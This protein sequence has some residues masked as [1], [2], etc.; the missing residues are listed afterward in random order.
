MKKNFLFSDYT[1][2]AVLTLM[3]GGFFYFQSSFFENMELMFYDLRAQMREQP[4]VAKRGNE[5]VI[6]EID[7]DS[8]IKIGRWPW[9]RWRIVQLIDE[10]AL[11]EPKVVAL[12]LLFSEPESN[13]GLEEIRELTGKYAFM[14]LQKQ[15]RERRGVN[16]LAELSSAEV[17]LDNDTKLMTSIYDAQNVLLAMS[18]ALGGI[19]GALVPDEEDED[20]E[21]PYALEYSFLP[22]PTNP[23]DELIFPPLEAAGADLPLDEF[24]EGSLGAGHVTVVPDEDGVLR[25]ESPFIK[26]YGKYYPSLAMQAVRT[27]LGVKQEDISITLGQSMRM[28]KAVIPLDVDNRM[29][30]SYV[31]KGR[32][33]TYFSYYDV[34][35]QK[36]DGAAFKNKIVLVAFT[37][38]GLGSLY[39]T[40]L[41]SNFPGVEYV[42][43]VIQNVLRQNFITRPPW[44]FWVEVGSLAVIGLFVTLLLPRLHAGTGFLVSLGLAIALIAPTSYMFVKDGYWIKIFYSFFLLAAFGSAQRRSE[45]SAIRSFL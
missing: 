11:F 16:F 18:F 35:N 42:A 21:L 41:T 13:Q 33:F 36:V 8:I 23:Q 34:V 45:H 25:H 28:G 7:N 4:Q 19:P 20:E 27:Y 43:N 9:P 39:T 6:V 10:L 14:V 2:G 3:V 26:F 44:A 32:T 5:V 22:D 12:N 1:I 17:R 30:I 37:A 40:P 29:P 38:S 15:I 24:A 31:G